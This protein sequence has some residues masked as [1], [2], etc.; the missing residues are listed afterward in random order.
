M[1]VYIYWG[2]DDF[3]LSKAVEALRAQHLDREW[4]LLNYIQIAP[5]D[6]D[7]IANA[8]LEIATAPLGEGGKIVHLPQSTLLGACP[9]EVIAEL[10]KTLPNIPENNILLITSTQKPDERNK[11]VK[12]ILQSA[13]LKTF[14]LIP[15][16]ESTKIVSQV[17][18]FASSLGVKLTND[19]VAALVEAVGNNSRQ[20]W[21]ELEKLKLYAG[22]APIDAQI[23]KQLVVNTF[24]SSLE[25]AAACR[26]GNTTLALKQL[27]R[28]LALNEPPL[29]IVATLA[30]CFRTWLTA[31]A[32]IEAGWKDDAEIALFVEL[33]NPKRLFFI[34][35]E[36]RAASLA[37]LK[38]AM[39]IL[40]ELEV[41]LKS[42][43][44]AENLATYIIELCTV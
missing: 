39:A 6:K 44:S 28:L 17:K 24:S 38:K 11:S 15:Q 23:I 26:I 4:G 21:N 3:L 20:A 30:T 43:G 42:G 33:K 29:R 41:L 27:D 25:L 12:L 40:L 7:N 35:Q 16:W 2:E 5:A 1:P 37:K 18:S 9:P 13:Q 34:K 14:P 36:I 31:K 10:E 8:L 22:D 19:A 32:C